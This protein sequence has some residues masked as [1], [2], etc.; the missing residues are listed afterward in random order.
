MASGLLGEALSVVLVQNI[1]GF[2]Q[3]GTLGLTGGDESSS[4]HVAL[5]LGVPLEGSAFGRGL[6][7]DD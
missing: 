4:E 5:S 2:L 1:H 3:G 7:G 6:H